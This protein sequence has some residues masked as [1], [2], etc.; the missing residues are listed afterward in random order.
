MPTPLPSP[1]RISAA[2]VAIALTSAPLRD[3]RADEWLGRDKALHFGASAIIAGGAYGV[4]A[5]VLEPRWAR[6][7]VSA[8]VGLSVGAAKELYDLAGRG[9]PSW[10]DFT[11]DAIG[12]VVGV[13]VALLIDYAVR[14]S[15]PEKATSEAAAQMQ[16]LPWRPGLR[17]GGAVIRF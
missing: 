1:R 15:N 9:D 11:W 4:S 5:L 14:G 13:G 3:A 16:S 17:A 8:S 10:K 12:T 7:V 6:V 2:L